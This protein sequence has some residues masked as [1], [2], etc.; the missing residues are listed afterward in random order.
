MD[1]IRKKVKLLSCAGGCYPSGDE[2]NFRVE[3]AAAYHV[4]NNW[5]ASAFF[6]GYDVGQA[7]YSGGELAADWE[8][9]PH[10]PRL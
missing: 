6:D 5:P 10:T 8:E 1:L 2:F 4:I 3:P 7:I 9:E